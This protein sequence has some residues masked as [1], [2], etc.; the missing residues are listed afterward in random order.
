MYS[1]SFDKKAENQL[2][3]LDKSVQ[4]RILNVLDRI[5]IRPFSYDIKR[6]QGTNYYRARAG[7]YRIIL[8]IKQNQLIIIVIEIGH[9]KNIYN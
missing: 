7:E 8:D 1:V 5:K 4:E 3:K 9:R 2:K 6:L